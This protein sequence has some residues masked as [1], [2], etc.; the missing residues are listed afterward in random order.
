MKAMNDYERE[1]VEWAARRRG[2]A[3]EWGVIDCMQLALQCIDVVAGTLLEAEHAGR[4]HDEET[5]RAYLARVDLEAVAE[6]AGYQPIGLP[7]ARLGDVILAT[8]ATFPRCAHVCLGARVLSVAPGDVV[9]LYP[10]RWL[11]TL[12]VAAAWGA[13]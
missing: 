2:Q 8:G 4:Y 11:A 5:A 1:L 9:K 3:F 7:F 13:R 6:S 10:K 12:D